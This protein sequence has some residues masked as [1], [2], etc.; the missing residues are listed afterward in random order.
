MT[1][2]IGDKSA[3]HIHTEGR[4]Y[5]VKNSIKN[6]QVNFNPDDAERMRQAYEYCRDHFNGFPGYETCMKWFEKQLG[7]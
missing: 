4:S 3:V 6:D 1:K 5:H 2:F 7:I